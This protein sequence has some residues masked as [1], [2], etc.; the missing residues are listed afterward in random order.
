MFDELSLELFRDSH[1]GMTYRWLTHSPLLCEQVDTL[2]VPTKEGNRAYWLSNIAN[3]KRKDFAI[4]IDK[5]TH[6]G[7]CG[8]NHIDYTR[9]KAELWIYLAERYGRG[10]GYTAINQLMA[11]GFVELGLNKI[12]LRVA[13]NNTKASRLYK[14]CGF[15]QDGVLRDESIN[16]K[17]QFVDYILMTQLL[18]EY[19]GLKGN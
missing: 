3:N 2:K 11:L 12:Y 13:A 8:L 4:I 14:A 17:G 10:F 5:N 1:I 9:M 7:N 15:V 18:I 19:R 16:T 6:I